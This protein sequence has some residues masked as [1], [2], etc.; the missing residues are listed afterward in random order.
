[1]QDK[2]WS[3]IRSEA[4]WSNEI[5][6]KEMTMNN[7]QTGIS[8][9]IK[10]GDIAIKHVEYKLQWNQWWFKQRKILEI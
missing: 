8:K 3:G 4:M 5:M 9:L 7:K 1:V 2:K 6:K 10:I